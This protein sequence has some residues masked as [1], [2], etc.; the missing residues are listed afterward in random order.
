M[1]AHT[2]LDE[3]GALAVMMLALP[4]RGI[5]YFHLL[6]FLP[7]IPLP[8]S[9]SR[10]SVSRAVSAAATAALCLLPLEKPKNCLRVR[11]K[12]RR[13]CTEAAKLNLPRSGPGES[14]TMD[15][16]PTAVSHSSSTAAAMI[17]P[18][19]PLL[20]C[21]G[22]AASPPPLL[23]SPPLQHYRV[24]R[25]TSSG[26]LWHTRM[27][28][29][30]CVELDFL[31]TFLT[32][33]PSPVIPH[34]EHVR[35]GYSECNKQQLLSYAVLVVVSYCC[36]SVYDDHLIRYAAYTCVSYSS[37]QCGCSHTL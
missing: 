8:L 6:Y 18:V 10:L 33:N 17:R 36:T 23:S 14:L 31:P 12:K 13:G 32:P 30:V 7:A 2:S 9:G 27:Q 29:G 4:S 37:S 25:G 26:R 22:S 3:L 1:H 28:V 11:E 19:T 24:S 5:G 35:D 15:K 16:V 34:R 21:S 20:S